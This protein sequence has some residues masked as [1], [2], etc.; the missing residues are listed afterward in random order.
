[1]EEKRSAK[2]GFG[3]GC[4]WCTEAVFQHVLGVESV[5]QGWI[6]S[7]GSDAAFS[8]AVI[9]HF[10]PEIIA[11][12]VLVEIHLHTH[13]STKKHSLRT[14]YRSA[15]YIF[16]EGQREEVMALLKMLQ[17]QFEKELITKVMPFQAFK[18]SREELRNYYLQNPKKPFCETYINPKLS[19][20]IEKYAACTDSAKLAHLRKYQSLPQW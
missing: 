3:G 18:G 9:V 14:K 20:L 17:T 5:E 15:I 1:M 16:F 19:M 2:I 8:E 13:Q 11:L 4:H 7:E 12:A 6:A 10:D